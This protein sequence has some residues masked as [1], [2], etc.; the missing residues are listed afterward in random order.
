MSL[1]SLDI[2]PLEDTWRQECAMTD[3][4]FISAVQFILISKTCYACDGW[5]DTNNKKKHHKCRDPP[6]MVNIPGDKPFPWPALLTILLK[7]K[8]SNTSFLVECFALYHIWKQ[9]SLEWSIL[10][11]ALS[12]YSLL[13]SGTREMEQNSQESYLWLSG[14]VPRLSPHFSLICWLS[15]TCLS[16][17][18]LEV[19][20]ASAWP[21]CVLGW[22]APISQVGSCPSNKRRL[23]TGSGI[24]FSPN[25]L[26]FA[27]FT[28]VGV[29]AIMSVSMAPHSSTLAWKIL[30][31]EEPGRLQSMGSLRVGY[32]WAISLSLFTFMHW[33]RK[34]QPTPKC[35]CLEN[36][37]DG[38]AW[39]AAVYGVAQSRTRLKWLSSSSSSYCVMDTALDF[40]TLF[41]Q[42]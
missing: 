22:P 24:C 4:C 35:S 26:H 25:T 42:F 37:R 39:W 20:I 23:R 29:S 34:W 10:D 17:C 27:L 11:A 16:L 2:L 12:R 6:G 30:W 8:V 40:V 21:P 1:G 14:Q 5:D 7:S 18:A 32:D 9:L 41:L 38:G 33:R 19:L 13:S 31:M 15:R 3:E 28:F 36:P